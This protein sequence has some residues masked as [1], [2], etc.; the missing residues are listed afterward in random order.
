M[1]TVETITEQARAARRMAEELNSDDQ[2]RAV[3]TLAVAT[4]E[5]ADELELLPD[6]ITKLGTRLGAEQGV[7]A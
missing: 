1:R 5:M 7:D 4:I 3:W 2:V 6:G